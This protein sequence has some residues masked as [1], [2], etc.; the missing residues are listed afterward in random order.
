MRRTPTEKRLA[1]PWRRAG[2]VVGWCALLPGVVTLGARLT[3][4][5]AGPLA[6]AVAVT[7]W[8]LLSVAVPLAGAF[9]TRDRWLG[10]ASGLVLVVGVATQVPLM[11][12]TPTQGEPV[13]TVASVNA[14][15]GAVDA[16]AV[17]AL[18]R[19]HGV[20]V[21]A[22]QELTPA[23]VEALDRAGL[24]ASLPYAEVAPEEG[25]AGIGLWSALPLTE[26]RDVEGTTARTL[27]AVVEV[28]SKPV[29]LI[30]AHPA[31][32][33]PWAH[34]PWTQDLAVLTEAASAVD[35][36]AILVGDLN[37]TRDHASLRGLERAGFVDAADEAGAGWR[38]T[39]PEQRAGFP[40]AAIDHV[41]ARELPWSASSL[42]TQALPGADHRALVVEYSVPR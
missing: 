30:A 36:P 31:A 21:L 20:D 35:G 39:F 28:N 15:F 16:A 2:R 18:V 27:R 12:A 33:G 9:L 34:A 37:A 11:T 1:Q 41:M 6:I 19:D 38:F 5:E 32:P 8:V 14:T 25:F 42:V 22:V 10:A 17:T 23:A 40:V 7:P 29:T 24:G 4:F 3:G 13:L 26:A